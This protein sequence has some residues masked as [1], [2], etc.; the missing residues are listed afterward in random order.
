MAKI[1][2]VHQ[3][4]FYKYHGTLVTSNDWMLMIG[5]NVYTVF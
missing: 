4:V 5:I 3:L 2:K 1:P